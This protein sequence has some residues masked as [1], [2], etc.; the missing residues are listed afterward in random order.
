MHR[1]ED[2]MAA[3]R[4]K[5]QLG[6]TP[7]VVDT[8]TLGILEILSGSPQSAIQVC[9][10]KRNYLEDLCLALASHA[11]G[12]QSDATLELEKVHSTRGDASAYDYATVHSQWGQTAEALHWLQ[13]A[14]Q[15]RDSG[16]EYMRT[17]PLLDPIRDTS[18]FKDLLKKVN[19]PN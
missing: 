9:G 13:I 14:Y 8:N 18:A 5:Q 4:H 12:M 15:K 1:Y 19:F 2:A 11:I 7:S 16:I 17:D 6:L 10:G 3:L